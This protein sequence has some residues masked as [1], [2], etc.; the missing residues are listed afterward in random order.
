MIGIL[1]PLI[2][3]IISFIL[4]ILLYRHFSQKS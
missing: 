2:I 3:L 1:I 4:T